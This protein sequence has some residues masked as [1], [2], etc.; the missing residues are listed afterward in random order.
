[1]VPEDK[2]QY[3]H[4][5]DR[6]LPIGKLVANILLVIACAFFLIFGLAG[7]IN[8][9]TIY[10]LW[11]FLGPIGSVISWVFIRVLLSLCQDVKIIRNKVINANIEN[12]S[13]AT[14]TQTP[15]SSENIGQQSDKNLINAFCIECGYEYKAE[16]GD[17]DVGVAPNTK[18]SDIP[19]DWTCPLCGSGKDRFIAQ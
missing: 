18:F 5:D 3:E 2:T 9:G 14:E 19:D 13:T 17:P 15:N 1:M 12:N 10:L 16:I 7:C 8:V 11:L 4:P 6:F